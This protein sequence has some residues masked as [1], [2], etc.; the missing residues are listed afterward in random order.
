MALTGHRSAAVTNPPTLP[1]TYLPA[2]S[3]A[4]RPHPRGAATGVQQRRPTWGLQH[5]HRRGDRRQY[6]DTN[7]EEGG[8]AGPVSKP[9]AQ[10]SCPGLEP[11]PRA[12]LHATSPSTSRKT[13]HG[14]PARMHYPSREWGSGCG[15]VQGG[16]D[17]QVT[18]SPNADRE[19]SHLPPARMHYPSR[20]WGSG[21]GVVGGGTDRQDWTEGLQRRDGL[22]MVYRE[23]KKK[24]GLQEGLQMTVQRTHV[25]RTMARLEVGKPSSGR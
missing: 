23:E 6:A 25:T 12:Q 18:G 13:S 3:A 20:D 5:R 1:P 21:R 7:I 10:T 17:R 9:R 8:S 22:Q 24:E 16:A 2:Y 4:A 14:P 19:V 15:V 11:R